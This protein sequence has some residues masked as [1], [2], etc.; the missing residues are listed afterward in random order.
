MSHGPDAQ[1]PRRTAAVAASAA[2]SVLPVDWCG[3]QVV[4][5]D[6]E[7][8]LDN[9]AYRYHAVYAIPADAA[10]RLPDVAGRIQSGLVGASALLE[11]LYARAI[12]LDMGTACGRQYVDIT[13]L[14]LPQTTDELRDIAARDT[15]Y[16][17]LVDDLNAAGFPTVRPTEDPAVAAARSTNW[18]VWLDGPG[19]ESTCGQGTSFRDTSRSPANANNDGG[20]VAAVFG[21]GGRFCGA[22]AVRHEIGH[23]LGALQRS[24]PHAF[25]GYHCDDSPGDTMCVFSGLPSGGTYF[26]YGNDDY[27]DPPGGP[28]L[29]WWTV[30]LSRFLCADPLCNVPPAM[31]PRN[32]GASSD[33]A[34]V[35]LDPPAGRGL[36]AGAPA[37]RAHIRVMWRDGE[38]RYSARASG[39]GRALL[40]VRCPDRR[41]AIAS[42]RVLLP[43]TMRGSASCDR[44]PVATVRPL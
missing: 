1:G 38:W 18:V 15:T 35:E 41:R 34:P 32:G 40:A 20:Q 9:G 30:D 37:P 44:A 25:D 33:L 17:V 27:W 12:R 8:Q 3:K 23:T 7:D 6:T 16:D 31:R 14:R 42:R 29:P 36:A 5:D 19:P 4:A 26:D 11:D 21:P 43:A 24:A 10:D 39:R 2:S 13:T 28:P 22:D